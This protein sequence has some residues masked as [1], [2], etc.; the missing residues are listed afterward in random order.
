MKVLGTENPADPFVEHLASTS[1]SEELLGKLGRLYKEGGAPKAQGSPRQQQGG[2]LGTVPCWSSIA[3]SGQRGL[4]SVDE[5]SPCTD[6]EPGQR[7]PRTVGWRDLS[8]SPMPST[9]GSLRN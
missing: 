7:Q 9:Q 3:G 8:S 4:G 1:K 6:G 5:R 2:A